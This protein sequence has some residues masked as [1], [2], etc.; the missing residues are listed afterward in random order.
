MGYLRQWPVLRGDIC[1]ESPPKVCEIDMAQGED[2]SKGPGTEEIMFLS[3]F[4]LEIW[5]KKQIS[6]N[7]N[8]FFQNIQLPIVFLW[9][10]PVHS[11]FQG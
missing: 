3:A 9:F 1:S 11:Y 6:A 5:S 10:H 7:F 8:I 4:I 2:M